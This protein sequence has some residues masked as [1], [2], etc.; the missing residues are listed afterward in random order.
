MQIGGAMP[1]DQD[2]QAYV[3]QHAQSAPES[4]LLS[5]EAFAAWV[6]RWDR[7]YGP[8][9]AQEPPDWATIRELEYQ[10]CA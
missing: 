2:Y 1:D 6:D 9:W 5:P 4:P 3:R 8:A 7:E 10:L